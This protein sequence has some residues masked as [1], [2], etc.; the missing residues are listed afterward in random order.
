[1]LTWAEVLLTDLLDL[2]SFLFWA[3]CSLSAIGI[4]YQKELNRDICGSRE[5]YLKENGVEATAWEIEKFSKEGRITGRRFYK[6]KRQYVKKMCEG[7]RLQDCW[8]R[9]TSMA[10][11]STLAIPAL[12]RFYSNIYGSTRSWH[13]SLQGEQAILMTVFFSP[14]PLPSTSITLPDDQTISYP[15]LVFLL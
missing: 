14:F 7:R 15:P 9:Q 12:F 3:K 5:R 8:L 6:C 4:W 2:V 1:M 10:R 11:H 13:V